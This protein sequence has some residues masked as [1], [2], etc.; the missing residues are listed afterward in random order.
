MGIYEQKSTADI[1]LGKLEILDP[2]AI[3][4]GGA[5]R[6][7][8]LGL[9]ASDIDVFVHCP[10]TMQ[11]QAQ[12]M[13]TLSKMFEV[14]VQVLG[15]DLAPEYKMNSSIEDVYQ[16]E[17][18]GTTVQVI[19]SKTPTFRTLE[20]FPISLSKAWYKGQIIR[21]ERSFD[22]SVENGVMWKTLPDYPREHKY[23]NKIRLKFPTWR[24]FDSE[25]AF[26]RS[27]VGL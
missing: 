4:A 3:I 23:L 6:D 8:S 7:W 21:T 24:Y 25:L 19:R 1:V 9:P 18:S 11:G 5:P 14:P 2:S 13:R 10:R 22:V 12:M 16:L 20:G 26:L 27:K 17:V 15:P